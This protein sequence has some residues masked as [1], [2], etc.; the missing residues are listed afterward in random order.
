MFHIALFQA[1][2][3]KPEI[4]GQSVGPAMRDR[5]AASLSQPWDLLGP[6]R[7]EEM[8]AIKHMCSTCGR[9]FQ[10]RKDLDRHV[11]TH[12]GSRPYTC[13]SCSLTFTRKDNLYQHRYRRHPGVPVYQ[14]DHCTVACYSRAELKYHVT[15]VHAAM[16]GK[17]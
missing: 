1:Y 9:S 5:S 10:S 14:C 6:M 12:T 3:G 4:A 15:Q 11:R 16:V 13:L 7:P 8:E 2:M 17:H